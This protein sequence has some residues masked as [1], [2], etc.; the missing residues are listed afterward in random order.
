MIR[1][2]SVMTVFREH[3]DE[4]RRRHDELWPEM[5]GMLREHG[6][7]SYSIFLDAETDRLFAYLEIEDE[8]RWARSADTDVCRRWW[9]YMRDIMETNPDDSPV[10][11]ELKPVFH[12]GR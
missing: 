6:M 3:H 12:L 5:E 4:Y 7:L 11:R 1:K 2:A 8:E 9:A 10:S